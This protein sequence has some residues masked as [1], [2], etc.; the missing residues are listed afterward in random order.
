MVD[1][2]G[3]REVETREEVRETR[4]VETPLSDDET[5]QQDGERLDEGDGED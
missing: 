2:E 3:G 4:E 1:Q 5:G